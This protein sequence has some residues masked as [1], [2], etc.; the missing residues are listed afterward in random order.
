MGAF[1]ALQA[2]LQLALP[3]KE[4]KGP[5][6]PKGNVPIYKASLMQKTAWALYQ[7]KH[8]DRLVDDIT[9]LVD[10][11]E[12]IVPIEAAKR[13]LVE[14]EITDI[15]DEPSLQVIEAAAEGVDSVLQQSATTAIENLNGGHTFRNIEAQD[16][17]MMRNGNEY[18]SGYVGST[19]GAGH[20]YDQIKAKGKSRVHN[21]N[22]YGGKSILDD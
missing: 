7:R 10:G 2:V 6:S 9:E 12:T 19:A 15:S 18:N 11:L 22:V 8:F 3:G 5:V 4:H 21:G 20:V 1:G 17:A 16:D 14:I 13:R